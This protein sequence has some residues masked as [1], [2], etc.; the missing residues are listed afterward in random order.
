MEFLHRNIERSMQ[1][2]RNKI[3]NYLERL[4]PGGIQSTIMVAFSIISVSIMLITG[5][6]MYMRFS[7]LSRQEMI[8]S[9][10][11]LMEQSKES[12]EDYLMNMRQISDAAYYSVIKESDFSTESE[13]IQKGMQLLYEAN[14]S[15]LRSIAIYNNFGSLIAAEPVVSQKEDP[16]VTKQDWFIHAMDEMENI[17]FS[18]PH[19]QNL[20]DD[21]TFRYYWVISSSRVVELTNGV[22]SQKGVLLVD[23]DYSE[24]SRMMDQINTLENGQYFY[25]C[26]S[27]GKIIYHPR[28]MQIS[29][30]KLSESSEAAAK[31]QKMI[32]DEYF[33]GK[34]RKVIVSPI[35]YTGWKLVGVIPY[36]IF[37]DQLTNLQCFIVML[38]LLMAMMLVLVNR[39]VSLRISSPILKLNHSVSEHE[40]GK[41]PD[42]YIGGSLEI[43]HLGKSI[44]NSYKRNEML[45]NE[46]VW[47]QNERR[48]SEL[49]AL[50]SQINPHFLY[51]TLDSITWMI[52]GERNDEAT[53]MISQLAKLF[54][55][56]LSKGHT[57]ISLK[58]ELQHAKSYMNI[59]KVRYKNKFQVAFEVDEEL[60]QYCAVKLTLQPILE[61]AINYGMSLLEEDEDGEIKVQVTKEEGT[62]ILSVIDNGIGIPEEEIEFLL[63]DTN[64]VH[65][66][67]S[68]VGLTNVNNRIQILFGKEYGLKIESELDEGTTVLIRIPAIV[69]TEENRRILEKGYLFSKD[70]IQKKDR[71]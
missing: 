9:T 50:Q 55:I 19:I 57:I 61:N 71:E 54:R 11:K 26:D 43:R 45:M 47:E 21:G 58:D 52:E 51:N 15:R 48:K 14:K 62:L 59:Q 66:K 41:E 63:M 28:Q 33:E 70:Q 69:Y 34:H 68:G 31:S 22:N 60:E 46:I 53:F 7:N 4:K 44:Q 10:Q 36:S 8:K 65:K 6:V 32:Y 29:D 16:N 64:R 18:I 30:G 27:N 35:S 56:S 38:M 39:I 42:I 40:A 20:F 3:A 24:I 23:M 17:H 2:V 37:T 12:M 13:E 67:G 49:D 1:K 5:I 25:L